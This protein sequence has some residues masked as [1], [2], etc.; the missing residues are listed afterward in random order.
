MEQPVSVLIL[1]DDAELRSFLASLLVPR[2]YRVLE[3]ARLAEAKAMLADS[4]PD[5]LIVDGLLPDGTGVELISRIRQL[6]AA[7]PAIDGTP[8]HEMKIIFMSAFW[9]DMRTFRTLTEDL[10][11]NRVINKPFLAN[12]FLAQLDAL[13]AAPPP[14]QPS[15]ELHLAAE[16][17]RLR[18]AYVEK[19]A[20]KLSE[21]DDAI[22][23]ARASPELL[24]TAHRL[25][26]RLH[27]T[28]GAHGLSAVSSAAAEIETG[29][30]DLMDGQLGAGPL[31]WRPVERGLRE[32]A[33]AVER[34]RA[35]DAQPSVEAQR[36]ADL[37]LLVVD[38]APG[39]L[40]EAEALGRKHLV[41]VLTARDTEEALARVEGV[42]LDGA[43][44]GLANGQDERGFAVARTLRSLDG[45]AALPIAFLSADGAIANRVA[46]TYAGGS[47][48]LPRPLGSQFTAVVEAFTARRRAEQPRVL[49]LDDDPAFARRVATILESDGMH[50]GE[51]TDPLRVLEALRELQPE[52]LLLDV[53][54]PE[55]SGYDVCKM[56][57]A[58]PE[59]H[60]LLIL[61]LT[62]KMAATDRLACF[63]AGG[64]DYLPKPILA[65]ELLERI[66]VR[67][68]RARM[69][70]ERASRDG[71]TGLLARQA[72][73]EAMEKRL[74]E[75]RR[76]AR[77][78]SL[79]LIDLDHFKQVND[80]YGHL[81]GDRVLRT[82]GKT[83]QARFR[84]E[85][86]RGRWGGEEFVVAFNGEGSEASRDMLGRVLEELRSTIFQG[87]GSSAATFSAT[88]SAGVALFPDD[89]LTL[90][91]LIRIADRRL[92][93]AKERGR[94]QIEI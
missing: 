68:D 32:L 31:V 81:A 37:R 23:A 11:V 91:E 89:G 9:R 75:N 17:A 30:H 10:H 76:L 61:F 22:R 49:I 46:A 78:L 58:M 26:H 14:E 15:E 83:L 72:F 27:G 45:R 62:V 90:E 18:Q 16:L 69:Q 24:E 51:L 13:R 28:A 29:L 56:L 38:D 71:L 57:R 3:A 66:R 82:L 44:I 1:D 20:D 21:L 63:Q 53:V 60:G 92:Y 2:G 36:A 12:E 87:E 88:F 86:I 79:C 94:N 85:D 70:R 50:V 34:R 39:G 73:I 65:P 41:H 43:I 80:R 19:L 74:A 35:A 64:D 47:L 42:M 6:E 67:L 84:T 33:G 77:P 54:M 59:W 4:V 93:T 7:T 8:A 5:L 48:F 52:V 55:L 25:A 40:A